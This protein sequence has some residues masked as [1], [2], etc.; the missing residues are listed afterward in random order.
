MIEAADGASAIEK[1]KAD[2]EAVSVVVLDVTMPGM[3]G[4][5]VFEELRRI[6]PGV[7][8]I[9]S[10][11]YSQETAMSAVEGQTPWGFVRKPYEIDALIKMLQQAAG[12][13]ST[14]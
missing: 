3:S 13:G 7:K 12:S 9:L 11:A 10:T 1:F 5:D 8:V 6:R 14:P 4:R 2:P